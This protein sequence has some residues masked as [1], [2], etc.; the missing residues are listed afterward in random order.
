VVAGLV[1]GK[2]ALVTGAG[3]GI[4]RASAEIF[5][6]EGARGVVVV[7][8]KKDGGEETV[9]GIR[10]AGGDAHYLDADVSDEDSVARMVRFAVDTYG[11]LDCAHNNAG[12]S[13]VRAPLVECEL[14]EWD[15]VVRVNLTSVFLCLKHELRQMVGQGGGAI[16][17]TS[18]AAG[19]VGIP[20][21]P[22]YVASKHG[23]LGLTKTAALE[24]ARQGIRVNAVCPGGIDT[25]MMRAFIGDDP[26]TERAMKA[27]QPTGELARAEQVAEA[28][29]WL[30][31]DAASFVNGETMVVDGGVLC[32]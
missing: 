5:V 15:R 30:C 2:V 31:S 13:G 9:A 1:E 14:A 28:V 32:R 20:G 7:D 8:V 4:G 18:S 6:R 19:L 23:V 21:L 27:A 26:E 12:V 25:P 29:V 17:N 22:H 11:A 3:G 10:S 16:V 24:F